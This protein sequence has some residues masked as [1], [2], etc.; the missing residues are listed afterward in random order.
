[1]NTK[2]EIIPGGC[3]TSPQ[4]FL[5]GATYAGIK[6]KSKA[7]LDLSVLFCEV[8]CRTAA[9]F[10][11]NKVQAAPV[12]LDRQIVEKY[13]QARAVVINSG[14]ANACTGEEGL[15]NAG[16][17]ARLAAEKLKI[18]A[19]EVL[20]AST[21]VIGVQLPM[22]KIQA[23]IQQVKLSREGGN[24]LTR[25]IM[26]TDTFP[27][28]IAVRVT[29]GESQF[30]IG[31]AAKGAGMIHPDMATMLCFLTTDAAVSAPFLK[32]ALK[33]SIVTSFNMISVDGDTSTNDTAILMASGL[34]GNPIITASSALAGAFQQA[35]TEVCVYLAKCIAR[36]GEGATRLIEIHVNG[37]RTAK[38]AGKAARVISSSP[39]VKT[40]VHG[41]DPNWGRIIAA[42]G[43]SRA[44]LV[45]EK[46]DVY[47]GEYCLLKAGVPQAF[48]KKAISRLLGNPEVFIRVELNLGD[49]RATAWGCD[50]SEEYVAVN[51]EYTT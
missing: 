27:K 44:E 3:T 51:A 10:T 9:T 45:P 37:A 15:T 2:T 23:G 33:R 5:A 39:L 42:A 48:D 29:C 14:C 31:G 8:S 35:L 7:A 50:L 6:H 22:D 40:A 43:R 1:M 12:I 24:D 13:G 34:A 28:Q 25:A 36:D 30:V 11:T 4:G 20:V 17:T 32:A 46:S 21:G 38:E 26:T 47:I 18:K 19:E 49:G 16:T 41:C